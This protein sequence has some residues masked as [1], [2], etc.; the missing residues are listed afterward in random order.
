MAPRAKDTQPATMSQDEFQGLLQDQIRQ[1]VRLALVTV[2]EAEVDAFIGALPYQR[3]PTRRDQRN[4]YYTRSLETTVGVINALPV[5]RTRNGYK[6]HLFERYQR[7]R[8]ELDDAISD[9]FI[10]GVSTRG[11]GQVMEKLNG[12]QPS[13]STVSRV[14]HTLEEE[15]R[16]W[17]TRPLAARYAYAF[18]DGT[19]FTVIYDHQGHKTPILAIVGINTAGERAVLAFTVGDRENQT[20]WEDLLDELKQRGVQDIGLWITDGNPAMLNA[21]EAKFPN[22]PR[23]RCVKHKMENVLSYVPK[24]QHAQVE[25][26]L[27]AIFYQDSRAKAD[28]AVAAFCEKY[29]AIYPT[30]VAC[31]KRDLA[32]CLTFYAYPKAHWRTIRTTNVIE[33][34]FGEV[35]KRSHKM[36]AAFRNEDS[37]LLMFY[38]VIRSL[39]FKKIPMPAQRAGSLSSTLL[40]KT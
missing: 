18:A 16:A 5:P 2:L 14:Y 35:K 27:K 23:Q 4:G 21:L 10:R 19:Y 30:A 33:R 32:A 1:A 34:L 20:A 31:L 22:T 17:K 36:A 39:R 38:A 40:H 15:Y 11:V 29:A 8:A 25:P 3:T 13:P 12:S 9:M 28:Q 6:T 24:A 26:E 7:R 37:C